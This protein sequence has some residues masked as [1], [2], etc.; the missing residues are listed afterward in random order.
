MISSQIFN[1]LLLQDYQLVAMELEACNTHLY[2]V[3]KIRL[4]P[5]DFHIPI[6]QEIVQFILLF[7]PLFIN[8]KQE[9]VGVLTI[10]TDLG[11]RS[12]FCCP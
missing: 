2:Q 4:A 9:K 12:G 5:N 8:S 10:H 3:E 6:Q 1:Q 11:D 7:Q